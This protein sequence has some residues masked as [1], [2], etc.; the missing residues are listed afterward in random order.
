MPKKVLFITSFAFPEHDAGAI[1]ITMLARALRDRGREV[2]LCGV[3]DAVVFDGMACYTLNPHRSNR[4]MNWLAY[5]TLSGNAVSFVRRN[6]NRFDAVVASFLPSAATAKIKDLCRANG[7][8]FAVDC[9]EWYTPDEF[10]G[11]EGDASY[12][13]HVKLLTEVIDPS[14]KVI[15]ISS[16]LEQYFTGRGCS[17]LRVPSV[18]DVEALSSERPFAPSRDLVSVMYAGSPAKKDSL[19][20]VLE[21]IKLLSDA[22][23]KRL[24]FDFYGVS[25]KDLRRYMPGAASLPACVR[26][27]DR[28][29]RAKVV[30]ALRSSDFTVLMRDPGK[31]FA[32]AGMPT[33]VTESLGCGTPVIANIT[34]DLGDFLE[35]GCDAIVVEEYSADACARALRKAACLPAAERVV[36]REAA[37]AI[38]RAKLDY[39]AYADALDAFLLGGGERG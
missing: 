22:D 1:R 9:T 34:S 36:M 31:R 4:V 19:G 38:A 21:A 29:P 32:Q 3:G 35:D 23:L 12:L 5:R 11:G 37:Y 39:R 13:D 6:L 25:E 7:I 28:V 15:A 17:V 2:E 30:S 10:P 20:V 24:S 8:D 26:A 27:H 18:L 16:Y 33:K 14:V